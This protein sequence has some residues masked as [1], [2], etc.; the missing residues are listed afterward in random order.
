MRTSGTS[1][2]IRA[3][4]TAE[5]DKVRAPGAAEDKE[6]APGAAVEGNRR[7]SGTPRR[8]AAAPGAQTDTEGTRTDEE[9]EE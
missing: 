8:F 9:T 4:G 5:D 6:R 1:E 7:A 2:D 3:P